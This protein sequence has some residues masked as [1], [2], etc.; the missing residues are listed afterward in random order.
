MAWLVTPRSLGKGLRVLKTAEKDFLCDVLP[1]QCLV[2]EQHNFLASIKA[3]YLSHLGLF[4]RQS[5]ADSQCPRLCLV[6]HVVSSSLTA[7]GQH[8]LKPEMLQASGDTLLSPSLPE[9]R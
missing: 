1:I 8:F 9:I 4:G 5:L 7:L 6:P 3:E 2:L